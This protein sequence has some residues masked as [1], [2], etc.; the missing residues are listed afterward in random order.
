MY[1]RRST[2]ELTAERFKNPFRCR[3]LYSSL[4]QNSKLK[5]QGEEDPTVS[6]DSGDSWSEGCRIPTVEEHSS[7]RCWEQIVFISSL[8]YS[9]LHG[10]HRSDVIDMLLYWWPSYLCACA[11]KSIPL[12]SRCILPTPVNSTLCFS[13]L[14]S[15]DRTGSSNYQ[16]CYV[17]H[18]RRLD[19]KIVA[20]YLLPKYLVLVWNCQSNIWL[21]MICHILFLLVLS[22]PVATESSWKFLYPVCASRYLDP[23]NMCN[24]S[25]ISRLM[26]TK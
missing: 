3:H 2:A 24:C 21:N 7:T 12:L 4:I 13:S 19:M 23:V 6:A 25:Y 20:G 10:W 11:S 26:W 8:L 18:L 9:L 1:C 14:Y 17:T 16:N 15:K 22:Y 5:N